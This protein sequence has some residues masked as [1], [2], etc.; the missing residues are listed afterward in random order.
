M[1]GHVTTA[2]KKTSTAH[3]RATKAET[4]V[5][6]LTV[7]FAKRTPFVS[8]VPEG[9]GSDNAGYYQPVKNF[10]YSSR[11]DPFAFNVKKG[12]VTSRGSL[13][14]VDD[15]GGVYLFLSFQVLL[16]SLNH[17]ISGS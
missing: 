14:S 1:R 4:T 6:R 10:S 16:Q 3:V 8:E 5:H 15:E 7:T 13:Y 11:K 2:A 9:S 17:L 12:V